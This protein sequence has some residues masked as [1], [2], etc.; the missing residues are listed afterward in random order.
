MSAMVGSFFLKTVDFGLIDKQSNQ[1]VAFTTIVYFNE[2]W[3]QI[4][5]NL[6]WSMM[7]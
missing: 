5:F 1:L 7:E 4:A 6:F 2:R 3:M